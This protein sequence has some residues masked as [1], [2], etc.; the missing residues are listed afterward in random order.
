MKKIIMKYDGMKHMTPESSFKSAK[1]KHPDLPVSGNIAKTSFP[2][3][4]AQ[5]W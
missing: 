4:K 3:D 2:L 5:V 1:I